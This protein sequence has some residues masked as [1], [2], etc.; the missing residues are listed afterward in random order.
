MNQSILL[1]H[2]GSM[3]PSV[4]RQTF[5]RFKLYRVTHESRN[6]DDTPRLSNRSS[7]I[8]AYN[9]ITSADVITQKAS[10]IYILFSIR[11]QPCLCLCLGFSQIILM[12][13]FLLITLHFS[14]I[15]LTEDL[16][17][18]IFTPFKKVQQIDI[19][20]NNFNCQ[21]LFYIECNYLSL[22]MILPL[23]RS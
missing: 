10:A 13:P 11:Y 8:I 15:G 3:P 21:R 23:V 9:I 2:S 12:A 19:I 5:S 6:D 7:R 4:F 20:I 18:I 17:F 16:T 22:Q 14:Q 1:L